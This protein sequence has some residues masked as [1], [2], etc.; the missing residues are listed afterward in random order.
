MPPL[1]VP[2]ISCWLWPAQPTLSG[3]EEIAM[4]CVWGGGGSGWLSGASVLFQS[5]VFEL[6]A[7]EKWKHGGDTSQ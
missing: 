5:G 7:E 6:Q 3:P 2:G 4:V 1:W